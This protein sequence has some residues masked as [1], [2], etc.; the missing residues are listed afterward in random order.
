MSDTVRIWTDGS[1]NAKEK[2]RYGGWGV[3]IVSK[4][5]EIGMHGGSWNT[6]T[7]R[8][9]MTAL[10]RAIEA[11]DGSVPLNVTIYSD[12]QF[13]VNS[14]RKGWIRKWMIGGWVGVRNSDIWIR[15]VRAMEMRRKA[16]VTFNVMWVR[17]HGSDLDDDIVFGNAVADALA[18]YRSQDSYVEDCMGEPNVITHENAVGLPR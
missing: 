9:E 12:S 13:V 8:M 6:T 15:I 17:G 16:G 11:I 10:L 18:D 5:R 7:P 14:F 4:G 3:Y 2:H 1:C